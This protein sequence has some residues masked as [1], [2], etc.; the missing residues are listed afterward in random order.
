MIKKFIILFFS[1][2]TFGFCGASASRDFTPA[3]AE[4]FV[5]VTIVATYPM[6]FACWANLDITQCT[7]MSI[8]KHDGTQWNLIGH[9]TG[10]NGAIA[11]SRSTALDST[12]AHIVGPFTG[13]WYLFVGYFPTA[14]D[15]DV[16][17]GSGSSSYQT[18]TNTGDITAIT[19]T[20]TMIGQVL[21]GLTNTN[22][23]DGQIAHAAIWNAQLSP[24][25]IKMLM[26]G[27]LPPYV[28]TANLAGYW[29][30]MESTSSD[31]ALDYSGN[32]NTLTQSGT[33]GVSTDGPR[34]YIP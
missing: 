33:P 9:S 31:D 30:L 4:F 8:T 26:D 11:H 13:S 22:L 23:T 24:D 3:N 16:Y 12:Y 25:E 21:T 18:Q 17:V 20:R 6:T 2:I 10:L 5:S 29:P 1:I 27:I 15:R 19:P 14:L 28:K 32:G 7:L 34:V